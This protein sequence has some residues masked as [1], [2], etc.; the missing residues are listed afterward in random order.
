MPVYVYETTDDGP[1]TVFE[2]YQS[3][4]EDAFTRDPETGRPVRRVISGGIEMPRGKADPVRTPSVRHSDSCT[5][6]NP[7]PRA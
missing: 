6:C 1:R 3:I 7:R 5:C 4:R 2:R